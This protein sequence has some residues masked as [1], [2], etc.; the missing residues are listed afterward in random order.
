MTFIWIGGNGTNDPNDMTQA[1]NWNPSTGVPG[2][3]DTII[4]GP[5]ATLDAVSAAVL[6]GFFIQGG[7]NDVYNFTNQNFVQSNFTLGSGSVLNLTQT[8]TAV[9]GFDVGSTGSNSQTVIRQST[10]FGSTLTINASGTINSDAFLY[11][12]ATQGTLTINVG[13]AGSTAGDFYSNGP[14]LELG[15]T[16]NIALGQ[17]NTNASSRFANAGYILIASAQT[18]ALAKFTAP[19]DGASG[20]IELVRGAGG[21]ASLEIATN[22]GGGQVVE[23]GGGVATVTLDATTVLGAYAN[24]GTIATNV[25]QNSF[26]RFNLFGPGDTIDLAG[27][28]PTGLTYSYGNDA[29]WGN[30]VLTLSQSGTVLARLRMSGSGAY[31][32]GTGTYSAAGSVYS[33]NFHLSADSA[34][35]GTFLTVDSGSVVNAGTLYSVGGA[36]AVF[37]GPTASATLDWGT[38]GNWTGGTGGG[39]PGAY[40]AT[41]ITNSV[42]QL[43][44]FQKYVI[45]VASAATAGG[46]SL[47]D[48]FATLRIGAGLTLQATPG[49]S[50]GG[51]LV[52][53][54]GTIDVIAGGRLTSTN[55]YQTS[56]GKLTIEAGGTVNLSGIAPF[57]LGFGLQGIDVEQNASILGGTLT[58]TGAIIIGQNA[59]ASV[60]AQTTGGVGASVVASFTAVGSGSASD[61]NQPNGSTSS[62]LT[63]S[64]AGTVWR[65]QGGDAT[66]G[67]SGAMLVGGGGASVNALGTVNVSNGGSGN[68]TIDQGATLIDSGYAMLGVR[69]GATGIVTLQNG[70]H[71]TIGDGSN[72]LPQPIHVGATTI[73]TG[74]PPPKLTVGLGGY[75]SLTIASGGILSLTGED[76]SAG[77][78]TLTIG[79]GGGTVSAHAGGDVTVDNA[80]LDS[81]LGAISIGQ[82]GDGRLNITN[83]GTVLAGAGGGIAFGVVVGSR[84]Y[85]LNVGT[86]SILTAST[87]TLTIG[88]GIGTSLLRSSADFIDGRDGVAGVTISAGGSLQ[89]NGALWEGGYTSSVVATDS[90]SSFLVQG[91]TASFSA[92]GTLYTGSTL[93]LESGA[94]QFGAGAA[95]NSAISI[96]A[97]TVV[98]IAKGYQLGSKV[99]IIDNAGG[100][101]VN[102]GVLQSV[103]SGATLEIQANVG[104]S[105]TEA[106]SGGGFI[107]FDRLVA[108]GNVVALGGTASTGTI[109]LGLGVSFQGTLTG[110]YGSANQLII[111]NIGTV[112]PTLNWTQVNQSYGTL[113]V[114]I[115]GSLMKSITIAGFHPSGFNFAGAPL[116]NGLIISALD[117]APPVQLTES[118]TGLSLG[119]LSNGTN[120]LQG[121]VGT[122][123][124]TTTAGA[125][126]TLNDLF[127]GTNVIGTGTADAAGNVSI[128]AAGLG[129]GTHI[130]SATVSGIAITVGT[131][132]VVAGNPQSQFMLGLGDD[133]LVGGGNSSTVFVNTLKQANIGLGDGN[134]VIFAAASIANI[135]LGNG[136]NL[137]LGGNGNDVVN[138]GT[139]A[140]SIYLGNGNNNIGAGGGANHIIAGDGTN[141]ITLGNGKNE[142]ETGGGANT[143]TVGNGNNYV[144]AGGGNNIVTSGTG[145][146]GIQLGNGNNT[147]HTGAGSDTVILGDGA[148]SVDLGTGMSFLRVGN[149]NNIITGTSGNEV[150]DLHGIGNNS[151][152]LGNGANLIYGGGNATINLGGGNNVVSMTDGIDSISAGSGTDAVTLYSTTRRST[153][154]LGDGNDTV[155]TGGGGA[156]IGLGNGNNYVEA[157]GGNNIITVGSGNNVVKG[158]S[159]NDVFNVVHGFVHGNGATDV[160]NLS[161]GGG[162]AY[163][164][165]GANSFNIGA[166]AW[167]IAAATGADRITVNSAS[168]FADVELFDVT[169]DMLVLSNAAFGLGVSGLSG[170]GTQAVGALLSTTNDG[171]FSGNSLLA[172]NIATGVLYDRANTSTGGVAVATFVNDPAN[173]AARL[174]VGA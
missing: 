42:A 109:E 98:T 29:S 80:L 136:A 11:Q 12:N 162:G 69:Q 64:G 115:N 158:D 77:E 101:L 105:G 86:A 60:N 89:V 173:V 36:L 169:K 170:S 155:I 81:S 85:V 113:A 6:T 63:I 57:S 66:T 48:H 51:G 92:G 38:A 90:G 93:D 91:G 139:G 82:R 157:L 31:V 30:N 161:A 84:N 7:S 140:N 129:V 13:T 103:T 112:S 153:V 142:I 32:D 137:V 154:T 79:N 174:F 167:F 17:G 148:N 61:P 52:Q 25:L 172:Y 75:G 22:M 118:G 149:G 68:L 128:N 150:I 138:A 24:V 117:S 35:T 132:L 1:V 5:S 9:A 56:N 67:Y 37:N 123:S 3:G 62:T 156:T 130:L 143:I 122:I 72:N 33:S 125:V 50:S 165:W 97:G 39:L 114:S 119:V 70:A 74:A 133:H 152:T 104:G 10:Q 159:G 95:T 110:F 14:I 120:I 53:T 27:I 45:N 147:L 171:S 58:S 16:L 141:S 96:A 76:P 116:V 94:L 127:G 41:E 145:T 44:A 8:G 121:A 108:S 160:F 135:S 106:V 26:E 20:V 100:T 21:P 87:G 144:Q 4:V 111:D 19:M 28:S 134:N 88:G 164:G 107:K 15:G 47:D 49:Q 71:W 131:T 23:F 99:S 83:G 126:V 78:Y 40:Q 166:G 146:S 102:A 34:G 55:F 54:G 59:S 65:D 73:F 168:A 124:L 163:G 151:V 18:T 2:S 46:L 43:N